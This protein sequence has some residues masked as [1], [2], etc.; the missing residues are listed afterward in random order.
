MYATLD[1]EAFVGIEG[2][3]EFVMFIDASCAVHMNMRSH[4]GG[5]MVFGTC[6]F[7]PM[8]K[9]Q[10]LNTKSSTDSEIFGVSDYSPK[11]I[12]MH[13]IM[14]VQGYPVEEIII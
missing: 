4:S 5:S 6:C 8:S 13:L 1:L 7:S 9:M 2:I 12:C 14:E 10:K 11:V 3:C